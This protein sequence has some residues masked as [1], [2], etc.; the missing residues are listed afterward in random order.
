MLGA[1]V[2]AWCLTP[3]RLCAGEEP[4]GQQ[5]QRPPDGGGQGCDL[6]LS[7]PRGVPETERQRER[8]R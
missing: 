7:A 5:R 3:E 6:Q 8:A 1:G 4:P 2:A